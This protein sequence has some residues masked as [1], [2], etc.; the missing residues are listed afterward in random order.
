MSE[1]EEFDNCGF[2]R[3]ERRRPPAELCNQL[4]LE[5]AAMAHAKHADSIGIDLF[6][7]LEV[8][9]HLDHV[10]VIERMGMASFVSVFAL[11]P[12]LGVADEIALIDEAVGDE[13]SIPD[14]V[15]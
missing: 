11:H 7:A 9:E 5:L 4:H 3:D 12:A 13:A 15:C 6:E 10:L 8:S 1:A 2:R 14:L